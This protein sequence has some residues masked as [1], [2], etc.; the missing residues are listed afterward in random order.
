MI[1]QRMPS[2]TYDKLMHNDRLTYAELTH[3]VFGGNFDYYLTPDITKGG[4][5]TS[6]QQERW[7][8]YMYQLYIGE[9]K[10]ADKYATSKL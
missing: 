2:L 7:C 10:E 6:H 9:P 3:N 1:K 8:V 5:S 4:S